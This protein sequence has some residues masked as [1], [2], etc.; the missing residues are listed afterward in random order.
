MQGC[1]DV[2]ATHRLDQRTG[3]VVVLVACTVVAH[4]GVGNG[5][6]DLG[7]SDRDLLLIGASCGFAVQRN[8][9]CRFQGGEGTTC[10]P[11]SH[12]YDVLARIWF[13]I[14]DPCQSA[15]L[16]QGRGQDS[17]ELIVGEQPQSDQHGPRQQW[18]DDAEGRVLGG[19]RNQDHQAV[20]HPWQQRVLLRLGE[21]VDLVQEQDR[22]PVVHVP[23]A[24]GCLHDNPDVLDPR[25][26]C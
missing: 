16:G 19:R 21:P 24:S 23:L 4:G 2:T 22:L 6:L 11:A 3:D 15:L 10:V 25:G 7:Q 18:R 9:R 5:L 8:P 17:T 20:L 14:E 1:V 13:E 26:D 12:P